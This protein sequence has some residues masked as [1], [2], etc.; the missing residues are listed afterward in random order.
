MK[1]LFNLEDKDIS[2]D[3]IKE[4]LGY[5][6]ADL[7]Y[8]NLLPDVMTSTKEVRK[9]IGTEVYDHLHKVYTDGLQQGV[10]TYNFTQ[11]QS[12]IL[13]A[14]RYPILVKAYWLFA[15]N[16]DLAHTG[17]G[18]SVRAGD[19]NKQPW[20]WQIDED[21]KA[22]EKRFYRALDDL[23]DLLDESIPEGYAEMEE[24]DQKAT[25]Y[26]KWINS[27]SYKEIKKCFL[28]TVAKFNSYFSIE[29][30]LLLIKITP[31]IIEC[32]SREIVSRIGKEKMTFLKAGTNLEDKDKELILLIEKA[33]AFYSLAWAI[34][35]M[36]ATLFPEGVLQFQ[37]SD[38]TT[39]QAK[40]PAML[41][42]HELARQSF[43]QT[44]SQ[45]LIDI[46]DLVKP[47]PLPEETQ[48][49]EVLRPVCSSEKFI[50]LT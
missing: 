31:G 4:H 46:E 28:N 34:P 38:R 26:Y 41:N 37:V 20:Q 3:E 30:R 43:A 40:K 7:S 15:P 22:Q 2:S 49:R 39:T 14:L 1:L 32:E 50:S 12:V 25:L 5:V 19:N 27:D 13:R 29:S 18:R 6:D 21:N 48:T 16:N 35:R 24:A 10:Y 9:L 44:V 23:I 17:D 11:P 42:E 47:E 36:S 45:T 33:S 8:K